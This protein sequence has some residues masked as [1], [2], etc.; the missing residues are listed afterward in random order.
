VSE[1][2]SPADRGPSGGDVRA[3][4]VAALGGTLA[5]LAPVVVGQLL[6]LAGS[7]AIGILDVAAWT[8]VGVLTAL[9]AL[10]GELE[11]T[12]GDATFLDA[13][14]AATFRWRLMPSLLTIVFLWLAS[15]AGRRVARTRPGGSA[16]GTVALGA[17]GAGLAVAALA[18]IAAALVTVSIP[19]L[20]LTLEVSV[21]SA[22]AWG[23]ILAAAGAGVGAFLET[24]GPA[25]AARATRGAIEG[26]ALALGLALVVFLVVATFEP[27]ATRAYV[28]ALRGLGSSG[29]AVAGAHVLVLPTQSA[30][31]LAPA[32]GSCLDLDADPFGAELCPWRVS[33]AGLASPLS[34][35]FWLLNVVPLASA[36][37]AGWRAGRRLAR[38]TA[39]ATGSAAGVLFGVVAVLGAAIAA[40]RWFLPAP[41]PLSVV[42]V[43]PRWAPTIMALVAW[44]AVG[45]ALGGWLAS[46]SY[47]EEPEP[48][49][50]TSA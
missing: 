31:L 38:R 7:V 22:A 34:P 24:S 1:G 5:F 3:F 44:G 50:P 41:I 49:M 2:A 33:G 26:Y 48:P 47:A 11:A 19:G 39:L 29:V 45:G 12:A 15:R 43:E 14:G 36:A 23:G 8:R 10:R 28:D 6:A 27:R 4:G 30:L 37:F 40:P 20:D 9:L 35:W 16:A 18:G 25:P 32:A 13:A 42:G 21:A 17:A 46:R